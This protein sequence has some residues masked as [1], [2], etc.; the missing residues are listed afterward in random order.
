MTDS[1]IN[2]SRLEVGTIELIS[3]PNLILP[4]LTQAMND[5]LAIA[6]EKK[7]TVNLQPFNDKHLHFDSKWTLEALI[8]ILENAVKYAHVE[9]EIRIMVEPLS[10]YTKINI[11]NSGI[12]IAQ[13][14]YN[15]IFKRFYRGK[16]A[17][18]YEGIGLGLYLAT[19]V[20][21]NQGGYIMVDSIPNQHTTFSLFLQNCQK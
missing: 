12:G 14:E 16:N 18:Q 8:N 2:I 20:M 3:K 4:T 19:L 15:L 9:S 11:T 13:S 7:I 5:I 6:T 21:E 17:T 1:L 10:M